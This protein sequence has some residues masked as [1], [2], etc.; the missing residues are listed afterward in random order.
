MIHNFNSRIHRLH[1]FGSDWFVKRDDELSFGISGSKVRKYHSILPY[2]LQQQATKVHVIGGAYS[3]HVVG[4]LQ[5]LNEHQIPY[6]LHLLRPHDVEVKGNLLLT[7]MLSRV[8]IIWYDRNSYKEIEHHVNAIME[9]ELLQGE[10]SVLIPEGGYMEAAIAGCMTLAEEIEAYERQH[11][12]FDAIFMDAGTGLSSLCVAH[13]YSYKKLSAQ[14]H[15]VVMAERAQY[16]SKVH[17]IYP[18]MK[19]HFGSA[20]SVVSPLVIPPSV[21]KAFGSVSSEGFGWIDRM[22]QKEGILV[23]PIYTSKLFQTAYTFKSTFKRVLVVHSGGAMA[24]M[25]FE[26]PLKKVVLKRMNP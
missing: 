8:P 3:N 26:N 20:Y 16:E 19:N 15:V 21:G 14:V 11:Q 7:K 2:L 5:V 1:S 22:A 23:D 25:G 24:L 18:W 12:P 10:K 6:Q 9:E 4:F 17:S 13:Y